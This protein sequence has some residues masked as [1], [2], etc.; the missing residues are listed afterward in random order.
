MKSV[1]LVF[2][3]MSRLEIKKGFKKVLQTI[4]ALL[5]EPPKVTR[6][7][8]DYEKAMGSA[9]SHV[10]PDV[11]KISY[12]F[13]WAQ[14]VWRKIRD[15]YVQKGAIYKCLRK[16]MLLSFLPAEEIPAE[17]ERLKAQATT[18]ALL[19]VTEYVDSTWNNPS[20]FYP[21]NIWSVFKKSTV[22][23]NNDVKVLQNV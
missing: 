21:P 6:A 19:T 2:V 12:V 16:I 1:S 4:I 15:L 22:R 5:P 13:H 23:T 9:M 11:R 8:M 20:A 7:M 3:L 18:P 14:C 17:W 10:L